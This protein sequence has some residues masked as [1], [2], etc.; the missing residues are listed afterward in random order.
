MFAS[1]GLACVLSLHNVGKTLKV[2]LVLGAEGYLVVSAKVRVLNRAE[3]GGGPHH[4]GT[5]P[6]IWFTHTGK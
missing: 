4:L 5:K 2:I 1:G 6:F 3:T